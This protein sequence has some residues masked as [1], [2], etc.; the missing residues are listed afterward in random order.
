MELEEINTYKRTLWLSINTLGLCSSAFFATIQIRADLLLMA[1][2]SMASVVYFAF[3]IFYLHR[4][5]RNLWNGWG[6]VLVTPAVLLHALYANPA[7]GVYW[8]YISIITLFLM[9][10]IRNASIASVVYIAASTFATVPYFETNMLLRIYPTVL[11]VGG[12]SFCFAYLVE[13]LLVA[14]NLTA[15]H[16]PL[17]KV[18][19]RHTFYTAI[20]TAMMDHM[21]YKVVGILFLFDLDHFKRI[22]DENGHL[23]GDRILQEV[24]KIVGNRL[25][26]T[27]QFF[28]YGGEE[29]AVLLR[30]TPLQNAASLAEDIRQLIAAH[31]FTKG[32]KV[33]IS[34]GLSEVDSTI[35]VNQWI[36]RSDNA[37]YEAKSAGRNCIK[38]HISPL[39]D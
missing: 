27:D 12:F 14:L 9:L 28:R 23:A 38:I 10:P 24:A 6:F 33:T 5:H 15:T 20:N 18:L 2:L 37:L 19:N 25:R 3:A 34:G 26:E 1:S 35:G 13:K 29:F 31:T 17:T 21:R 4:H 11:L 16:D 8:I 7:Y 36:E 39:K 32:I 22:N 30:H